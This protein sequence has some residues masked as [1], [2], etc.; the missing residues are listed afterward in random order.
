MRSKQAWLLAIACYVP[1]GA[2]AETTSER[3]RIEIAKR[4]SHY[5]YSAPSQASILNDPFFQKSVNQYLEGLDP[6]SRL[7]T[8]SPSATVATQ[9]PDS[10]VGIGVRFLSGEITL[11]V[12]SIQG[13]AF[14]QGF[15]TPRYVTQING[16]ALDDLFSPKFGFLGDLKK[17]QRITLTF[18]NTK[19]HQVIFAKHYLPR[20]VES[21]IAKGWHYIRIDGFSPEAHTAFFQ[22]LTNAPKT[23]KKLLID[24]RYSLGGSLYSTVDMLSLILPKGKEVVRLHSKRRK[25]PKVLTTLDGNVRNSERIHILSSRYTASSAEI[26]IRALKHFEPSTL[27]I[28]ED[29]QGKCLAQ[30]RFPISKRLKLTL[31]RYRLE[32]AEGQFCQGIPITPD[33]ALNEPAL[34]PVDALWRS[35]PSLLETAP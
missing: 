1:F 5:H 17:N 21:S 34:V 23:A 4:I 13:P 3:E 31:S 25:Q 27:V 11:A 10:K 9:L 8:E 2:P 12:P 29:T 16:L 33:V 30:E 35:L 7:T 18:R 32:S 6:Y 26:F 20:N 19:K 15:T 22:A 14:S 28:G 24:L